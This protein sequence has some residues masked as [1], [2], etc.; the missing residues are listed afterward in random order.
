MIICC[1]CGEEIKN[2]ELTVIRG[3]E[4]IHKDCDLELNQEMYDW[5]WKTGLNP[6][7]GVN[8]YCLQHNKITGRI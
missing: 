1:Y 4:P 7:S 2:D 8:D 3:G 5:E 6:Q